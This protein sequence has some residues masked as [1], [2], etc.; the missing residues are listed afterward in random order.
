M[1]T[2][3]GLRT[4][5][6]ILFL[7]SQIVECETQRCMDANVDGD[8]ALFGVSICSVFTPSANTIFFALPPF[9]LS[10]LSIKK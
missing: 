10:L 1:C 8:A 7:V 5:I 4:H 9:F 2:S 6:N 3:V